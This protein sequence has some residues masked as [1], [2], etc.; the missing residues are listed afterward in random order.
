MSITSAKVALRCSVAALIS[1]KVRE[2]VLNDIK[3]IEDKAERNYPLG[4]HS[5]IGCDLTGAN[6]WL[7]KCRQS[8]RLHVMSIPGTS[9]PV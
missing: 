9:S 2:R 1:L 8:F 3:W 7:P 6:G 4:D 5:L